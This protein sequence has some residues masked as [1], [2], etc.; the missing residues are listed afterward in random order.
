MVPVYR[1]GEFFAV[2][3]IDSD[4]PAAFDEADRLGLEAFVKELR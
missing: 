2:L 1:N 3:D 4:Q